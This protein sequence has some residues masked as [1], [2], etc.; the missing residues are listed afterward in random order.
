M[1]S[2]LKIYL[3]SYTSNKSQNTTKNSKSSENWFSYFWFVV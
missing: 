3:F 2:G 1:M